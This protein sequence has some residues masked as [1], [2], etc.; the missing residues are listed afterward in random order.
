MH[1]LTSLQIPKLLASKIARPETTH[2]WCADHLSGK[3][4]ELFEAREAPAEHAL[5]MRYFGTK[6]HLRDGLRS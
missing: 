1:R 3:I 2:D 5:M 4:C 6:K